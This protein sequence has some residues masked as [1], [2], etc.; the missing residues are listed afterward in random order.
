VVDNSRYQATLLKNRQN[1]NAQNWTEWVSRAESTAIPG[2]VGFLRYAASR[3]VRV[4]YISNRGV[5]EKEAT[6]VNL[7]KLGF[8]DISD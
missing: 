8:P 5:I 4:F 7:K 1:Y 2:A 3:S 6:I